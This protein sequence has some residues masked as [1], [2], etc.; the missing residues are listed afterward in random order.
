MKPHLKFIYAGLMALFFI[1]CGANKE[2]AGAPQSEALEDAAKNEAGKVEAQTE[3]KLIREGEMSFETADV[4][5]TKNKILQSVQELNGYISKDNVYDYSGRIEHRL[6]I[7]VPSDRFDQ[8]LQKISESAVKIDSKSIDVKD[9]T[10][11]YIDV[12]AR[13]R[14]KKELQERY[15]ELLKQAVKV[16]EVLNIEKE[17]GQLQA[18]IE[19]FEGRMKYLKDRI[20][21]ST[22]TVTYYTKTDTAFRFG[23]KFMDALGSG[24]DVFLWFLIGMAHLWVFVLLIAIMIYGLIRRRRKRRKG[25][26]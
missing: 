3:R 6:E 15:R 19:S 21:F 7:R 11:E 14:T 18:E 25:L 24:W 2:Y 22:L 5:T 20:S 16:D 9:V 17:I 10:E 1:S 12:E 13:I 8:L 23:S 4:N 26:Q